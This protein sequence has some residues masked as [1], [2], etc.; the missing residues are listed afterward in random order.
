MNELI[1]YAGLRFHTDIERGRD[2]VVAL[3]S[4]T[5]K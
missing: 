3:F 1:K 4:N 2:N 5:V